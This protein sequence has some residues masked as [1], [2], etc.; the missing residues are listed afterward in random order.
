MLNSGSNTSGNGHE[1]K[2]QSFQNDLE[3]DITRYLGF[4]IGGKHNKISAKTKICG[5]F[6]CMLKQI[7]QFGRLYKMPNST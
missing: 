7:I 2:K 6:G 3:N 1:I 4:S 5:Y